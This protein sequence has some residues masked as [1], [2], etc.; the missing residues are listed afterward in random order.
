MAHM[1]GKTS[2]PTKRPTSSKAAPNTAALRLLESALALI[3][4]NGGCRGVNLRQI[5]ARAKCAHTNLYNYHDSLES[6]F[7]TA[8]GRALERL[9]IHTAQQLATSAGKTTPL[10]TF[11][12]AQL[13]YAQQHPGLYRLVWLEP[14]SGQPP[15]Q[16]LQLLDATRTL[17]VRQIGGHLQGRLTEAKLVWAGQIVHGYFHGE[18]CKLIGRH[19]FGPKSDDDRERILTNTLRLAELVAT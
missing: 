1:S 5:A 2:R 8:M 7:W 4:H 12:A 3:D 11:L 15:A 10:R 19:A 6:L 18:V 14:L 9:A 16:V 13:D 17:W